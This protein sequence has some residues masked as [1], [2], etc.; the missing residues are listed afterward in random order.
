MPGER[1]CDVL[2]LCQLEVIFNSWEFAVQVEKHNG[3]SI[4]TWMLLGIR[5]A[6]HMYVFFFVCGG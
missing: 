6:V 1:W 3:G 2:T 5:G 4:A